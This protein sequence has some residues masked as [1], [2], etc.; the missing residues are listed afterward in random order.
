MTPNDLLTAAGISPER[1]GHKRVHA[2]SDGE[3]G[4]YRWILRRFAAGGPPAPDELADAASEFELEVEPALGRLQSA[5]LVHHDSASG[6]ILV[7][8]PFSGR[9]TA[10]RVRIDG[11]EVYAMCALDALGIAPMLGEPTTIASRDPL[12]GAEI[13]VSLEPEGRGSWEPEEAVLVTGTAGGADSCDACCPVLNF[14]ASA[15]NA[16]RWLAAHPSVR[17]AVVSLPDAIVAGRSLFGDLLDEGVTS[18]K[19]GWK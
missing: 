15:E 12:T 17:G 7:A 10:H 3:R 18:T 8:Y 9:Q 13:E 14:F 11:R 19:G 2:L 6:A 16:E 1:R 4:F 5:D